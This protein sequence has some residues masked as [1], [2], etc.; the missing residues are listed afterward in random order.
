MLSNLP[1]KSSWFDDDLGSPRKAGLV[2]NGIQMGG[3]DR[4]YVRGLWVV[5]QTS[6]QL[7]QLLFSWYRRPCG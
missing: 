7:L 2:L 1:G 3:D 6:L 4:G 5:P